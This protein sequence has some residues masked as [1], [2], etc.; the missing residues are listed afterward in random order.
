MELTKKREQCNMV[1]KKKK[2]HSENTY[3]GLS[4]HFWKIK[5]INLDKEN[6]TKGV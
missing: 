5:I 3:M 4:Y 1:K 2:K 6:P